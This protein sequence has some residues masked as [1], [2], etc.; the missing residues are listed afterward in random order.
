M[1]GFS[2][3]DIFATKG[4][5]Y[6]FIIGFFLLLVPFWMLLQR[7]ARAAAA[8]AGRGI[9]AAEEWFR[10]AADTWFHQG[11]TWAR[12]KGEKGQEDLRVGMDDFAQQLVGAPAAMSLPVVGARVTQGQV[13]FEMVAGGKRI[14]MLSPVSGFV[15]AVNERVLAQPELVNRS[16]YEDGWLFDV[17]APEKNVVL[18]N[19]LSGELAESWMQQTVE[20]LRRSVSGELGVAMQDGGAPIAGFGKQMSSEGWDEIAADYFMT[21]Q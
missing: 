19:L 6:V 13:G 8:A 17:R 16:P 20:K 11:H 12:P 2:Y 18:R 14:P 9:A 21:R 1:E 5:E 3:L 4:I 7:T 15:T 10:L